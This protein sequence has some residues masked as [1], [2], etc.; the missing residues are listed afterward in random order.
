MTGDVQH[1]I[2]KAMHISWTATMEDQL[3]KV[4]HNGLDLFR[5]LQR[6]QATF[7]VVM[8]SAYVENEARRIN[9]TTMEDVNGADEDINLQDRLIEV[10]VFP[11]VYKMGD[12]RGENVSRRCNGSRKRVLT[13]PSA[14]PSDHYLSG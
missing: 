4:F 14:R 5:L 8:A 2:V 10:S 6:Q 9:T 1:S 11:L 13:T 7:H 12:E 3:G